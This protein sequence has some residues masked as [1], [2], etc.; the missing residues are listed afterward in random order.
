VALAAGVVLQPAVLFLMTRCRVI[1]VPNE[2]SSHTVPTPRGGGVA[3]VA[4][5]AAG[6]LVL[7]QATWGVLLPLICYAALGLAE[8]V[9]GVSVKARL[10]AQ[11][12][13]GL[14]VGAV[15]VAH[16]PV[17][18]A[19][20]VVMTL[21]LAV[22]MTGYVNAFNFMDGING[23]AAAHTVVAGLVF[24]VIGA[25]R[26]LPLLIG[27]GAAV[28]AAALTFLPW[29]AGRARIFLGD[30]GSYGLGGALAALAAYAVLHGVPIEA[31][32]SPLALYL[33]DTG[34]TLLRRIRAG[35]RW[36]QAHRWHVFQRL[37]DV[38]FSHSQVAFGTAT[39]TAAL[40]LCGLTSLVGGGLARGSADLVG[41]VALILYVSALPPA[42]PSRRRP[43][44]SYEIGRSGVIGRCC[45]PEVGSAVVLERY[46]AGPQSQVTGR[47]VPSTGA[48]VS[49]LSN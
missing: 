10:V 2:R 44:T 35:Q 39:F 34:W 30:V 13:I 46:S 12:G 49:E 29:N 48:V 20:A 43:Q 27:A 8:D 40:S 38:G 6:L 23:I 19:V 33:A 47:C 31:A 25:V 17:S 14:V 26:D 4:A 21:I 7:P 24:V 5:A 22:W 1:D 28:V 41:V 16:A 3:V 42:V 37:V 15:L 36:Y 45:D 32:L 11:L 9:R 18:A